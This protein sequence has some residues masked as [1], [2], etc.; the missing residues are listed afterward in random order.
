MIFKDKY[1]E[2]FNNI[3]FSSTFEEDTI[4]LLKCTA[5]RKENIMRFERKPIK[6]AV[7]V[8][9]VITL[10]TFS[11]VAVINL[12]SAS[13]IADHFGEKDLAIVFEDNTYETQTVTD[14]EYTVAFL[15]MAPG[16]EVCIVD[17]AEIDE[18]R[19]YAVWALYRN[20]GT[21]LSILDGSPIMVMPVMKGYRPNVFFRF[22]MSA[23][24]TEKGGVLYYLCD[25]TDL[26]VFADKEVALMVYEGTFPTIKILTNND[27]GD[28][29]YAEGYEGIKGSFALNL[30]ISKA[31]SEKAA[32]LLASNE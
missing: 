14:G 29:V 1:K 4:A 16:K 27:N 28:V 26:E 10:L 24:G 23:H 9:A 17:G 12:L 30:D 6:I 21:P 25:Y 18:D 7:A 22:G 8:A 19:S 11:A 31:D 13:Q 32:E 15:G 2:D 5:T 3:S 20:D